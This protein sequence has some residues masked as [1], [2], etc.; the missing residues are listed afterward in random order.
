MVL[1]GL[2]SLAVRPG[3]A[4]GLLAA[5]WAYALGFGWRSV[6]GRLELLE[7]G[8]RP[9]NGEPVTAIV[10]VLIGALILV[11]I[12]LAW[13]LALA[14]RQSDARRDRTRHAPGTPCSVGYDVERHGNALARGLGRQGPVRHE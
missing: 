14:W 12:V 8:V 4:A 7:A 1:G 5:G 3:S 13:S 6:F 11:A 10:T 2:R 9:S